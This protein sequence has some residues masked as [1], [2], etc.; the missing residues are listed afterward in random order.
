MS[1]WSMPVIPLIS[2]F[3]NDYIRLFYQEVLDDFTDK[4]S[5]PNWDFLTSANE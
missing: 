2:R 1:N 5:V 4:W 3:K